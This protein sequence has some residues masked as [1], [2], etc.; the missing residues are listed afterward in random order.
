MRGG[1]SGSYHGKPAPRGAPY[2][3]RVRALLQPRFWAAHLLMVVAVAAAVLAGVWQLHVWQAGREAAAKDLTAAAPRALDSVMGG[4]DAFPGRYVG[5]PVQLEGRWLPESTLYVADRENAGRK[6]YWVVTPVLVGGTSAIPVVRGWSATRQ[7]APP[8]G[9]ARV[10]GWLQPSEGSGATDA[11]PDD[12]VIPEMRVASIVQHVDAD[13][14]SGFVVQREASSGAGG[15]RQVTPASIPE[16]SSTDHLRN[17]LYAFQWWIFGGFALYV[18]SDGAATSSG[19]RP[20]RPSPSTNP[21]P[22]RLGRCDSSPPTG[23]WRWSS[24]CC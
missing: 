16:V 13:L 18:W 22:V 9:P 3:C 14:Y 10:T 17:L 8:T 12:D 6:G 11:N 23:C 7:V 20:R 19:P 4:D 24:A 1:K 21:L 5:Q 15:L 2:P